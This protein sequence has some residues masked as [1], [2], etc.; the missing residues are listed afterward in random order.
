MAGV[1]VTNTG[2]ERRNSLNPKVVFATWA[3]ASQDDF[4][5]RL[6]ELVKELP[7]AR[8]AQL[9]IHNGDRPPSNDQLEALAKH[10]GRVFCVNVR[11]ESDVC[12]ALPIGLEN[13]ALN[14]NGKM[15]LYLDDMALPTDAERKRMAL[16]SFHVETNPQIRMR[17]AKEM[18]ASRHGFDGVK[19][20][21]GEYRQ[22]LR[23]TF[24]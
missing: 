14:V 15:S 16:A 24:S 3:V 23:N 9:L 13:A 18:R 10:I 7:N 4:E 21:R 22:E 6:V 11:N 8:E 17:V 12:R 1:E 19:W 5:E 2:V 20:K